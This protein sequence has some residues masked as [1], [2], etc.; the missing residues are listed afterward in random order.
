MIRSDPD[1][2][3]DP[4]ADRGCSDGGA[5]DICFSLPAKKLSYRVR[6]VEHGASD[7]ERE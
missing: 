1:A 7:L 6:P 3:R 5:A 2:G 4:G